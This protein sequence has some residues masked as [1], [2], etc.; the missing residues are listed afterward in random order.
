MRM[1][2]TA[3]AVV[4]CWC[5]LG[6]SQEKKD[7]AKKGDKPYMDDQG[8]YSIQ[9]PSGAKVKTDKKDRKD[10]ATMFAVVADCGQGRTCVVISVDVPDVG[11]QPKVFFEAAE[12]AVTDKGDAVKDRKDDIVVKDAIGY[13]FT[14]NCKDGRVLK[15]R[16]LIYNKRAYTIIYGAADAK[17]FSADEAKKVIESFTFLK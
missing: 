9:F 7:D 8:E 11:K 15:T 10:A 14:V 16:M 1:G 17:N 5:L 6:A 13:E 12:K 3:L 4:A 2:V